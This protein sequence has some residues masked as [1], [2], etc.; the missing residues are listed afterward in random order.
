MFS[1][2]DLISSRLDRAARAAASIHAFVDSPLGQR[3]AEPGV[4]NFLFGNPHELP[5][6]GIVA[7][8]K[9]HIEPQ[10]KDWFAYQ[11]SQDVACRAIAAG[12]TT[13]YGIPFEP[14]DVLLTTGAFAGLASLLSLLAGPGDEV[15]YVSPPW[16]FYESMIASASASPV[17]VTLTPPSFDLDI[18]AIADAISPKTRAVIINSA[19]NPTG[20]VYSRETLQRLAATL[21]A[22]SERIGRP[23]ALLSDEA[24]SRI[25]FDGVTFH[26]PTTYY[27]FAFLIYT[28]GKVLLT[29]G[30]RV[31]YIA[32]AP[33][34]PDRGLIRARL[35]TAL[36]VQGWVFPNAL[37]QYALPELERISIDIGQLQRR[38][39]RLVNELR[40]MGYEVRSPE[41]TF[42]LLPRSP[43]PDDQAFCERLAQHDVLCM[44]GGLFNLPG[45]FRISFTANDDMVERA[46]PG[47][48]AAIAR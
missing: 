27:P 44:P 39:D 38:R 2:S 10:H 11:T 46:L 20:R 18:D 30:Q 36:M 15:I 26:T 28:Y 7:A 4:A 9:R 34:M 6:P 32:L 43:I 45:F 17:R 13:R 40:G 31:G 3:A 47:F 22:A 5:L 8:L 12:L 33:S 29:P 37:M 25:L 16:F 19:H 42:Y 41:S 23:I 1:A 21:T 35:I 48:R 24:Y 14:R